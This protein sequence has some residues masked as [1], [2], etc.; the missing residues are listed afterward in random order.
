VSGFGDS[1]W[2]EFTPLAV[3]HEAVNLSQG[4]PSIPVEEFILDALKNGN[5]C[6]ELHGFK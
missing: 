5:N 2:T 1:V 3:K 4:L 6:F